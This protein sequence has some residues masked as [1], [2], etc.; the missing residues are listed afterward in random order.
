MGLFVRRVL[1]RG[2]YLGQCCQ[3]SSVVG[4]GGSVP[5]GFC[6]FHLGRGVLVGGGFGLGF[7]SGCFVR[8]GF[9]GRVSFGG[10]FW[11]GGLF[12]GV[13]AR[14]FWRGCFGKGVLAG[15]CAERG[16]DWQGEFL[17]G[18]LSDG[19]VRWYCL[20]VQ[21]DSTVRWYCLMVQSAGIVP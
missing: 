8:G 10:G 18:G 20:M 21:S 15:G 16:G 19:T 13:L 2:I 11:R 4:G 12:R 1:Y 3:G 9:S 17:F 7:F 6:P 14:G 5:V